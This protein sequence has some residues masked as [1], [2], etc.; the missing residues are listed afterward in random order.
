M[1]HSWLPLLTSASLSSLFACSEGS[2]RF[3]PGASHPESPGPTV[4][5]AAQLEPSASAAEPTPALD[6]GVRFVGRVD[7]SDPAGARFAWSGSGIVA[8]FSGTT[9][10]AKVTGQQYTV[11]VDGEVMPKWI[12]TGGDDVLAEGLA[13]GEHTVEI[14]RRTEA[15]QGES[16]F[17]RLTTDGEILTPPAVPDRRI[18]IIGDSITCGYGNE[19]ADMNCPF[20]ADTEN[21]YLTY[22]SLAA[23]ALDAELSTV[24]WSG[25]GIVCNYGDGATSCE[26]P[27]PTYY[28]RTLPN[29][30]DSVWDFSSWQPHAVV[31]NLGT[32]DLSTAEDPSEEQ[33][34]TAYVALLERIREVY[35]DALILCTNGPM[36]SGADLSTVRAYIASAI[37]ERAAAG[38]GRVTSFEF[39][40]QDGNLGY[41]CDWHPSLG[42]HEAMA[43]RLTGVLRDELGW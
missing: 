25:K 26:D 21:H 27:L 41:G 29:R 2:T 43:E 5:A 37:A 4:D 19:G 30:S 18:E 16:T 28:D 35:P 24:A 9:V 31:I 39:E 23:R 40:P 42:T 7:A 33:F 12:P 22:G 38:D 20:S 3:D 32:N 6:F 17:I 10:T 14:Y 1:S 36:L 34:V 11:V 13:D 8:R 15:N